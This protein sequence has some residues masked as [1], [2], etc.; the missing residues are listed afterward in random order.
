MTPDRARAIRKRVAAVR[1]HLDEIEELV[2]EEV[3]VPS[4]SSKLVEFWGPI[5]K[6]H[7][8]WIEKHG[9]ITL[10]ESL[11]IRRRYY[12]AAGMDIRNSANMFQSPKRESVLVRKVGYGTP[13]TDDQL[14]ELTQK[15][16]NL[17]KTFAAA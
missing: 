13:S 7:Q 16:K 10:K 8:E 2:D 12:E 5:L 9:K 11:E 14:V 4:E 15:G 3:E 1:K 17:L 6:D